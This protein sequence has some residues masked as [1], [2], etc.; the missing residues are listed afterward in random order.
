MNYSS[1][2]CIVKP[3]DQRRLPWVGCGSVL[4]TPPFDST[5]AFITNNLCDFLNIKF[6]FSKNFL[7]PVARKFFV[8]RY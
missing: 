3:F 7:N 5:S 4:N 1:A 8:F 6:R 2:A